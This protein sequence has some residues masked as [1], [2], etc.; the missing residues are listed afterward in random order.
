MVRMKRILMTGALAALMAVTT[1]A[2]STKSQ[3]ST[4]TFYDDPSGLAG[5]RGTL[6]CSVAC[7]ALFSTPGAYDTSIGGV[8]TVHPPNETTQTNFVNA[9]HQAGDV[10]FAVVDA[11]KTDSAPS[12]FSTNALYLLLKIGGGNTLNSLLVRNEAGIGGLELSW[13]GNRASGLSHYTEFGD[14]PT[15]PIPLPAGGLLL[16]TALGS[17]G[18]AARRRSKA[19]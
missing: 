14:L 13:D 7:S 1:V 6:T 15:V 2:F 17:L 19:A 12:S 8:F 5:E 9:N 18:F 3:A 16:V 4:I 10:S 11:N